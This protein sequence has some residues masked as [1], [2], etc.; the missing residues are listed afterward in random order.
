MA[1]TFRFDS[2]A[3]EEVTYKSDAHRNRQIAARDKES[4]RAEI[5]SNEAE[6]AKNSLTLERYSRR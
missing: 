6:T 5:F 4:R 1:K 3:Q 2:D